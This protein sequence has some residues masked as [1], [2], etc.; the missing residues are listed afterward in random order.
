MVDW[1]KED[2][3]LPWP[4]SATNHL[5]QLRYSPVAETLV[6]ALP[7][8]IVKETERLMAEPYAACQLRGLD[9]SS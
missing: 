9:R 8:R 5:D 6:M 3:D 7:K 4:P 2:L 1:P